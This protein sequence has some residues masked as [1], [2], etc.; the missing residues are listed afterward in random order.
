MPKKHRIL[1]SRMGVLFLAL[2]L[3]GACADDKVTG[4][5]VQT[6]AVKLELSQD[7]PRTIDDDFAALVDSIPGFGGWFVD[8]ANG[9]PIVV[10]RNLSNLSIAE[11]KLRSRVQKALANSR[12]ASDARLVAR[13]GD[14]DFRQLY[15]WKRI[16]ENI[17]PT[18]RAAVFVDANEALNRVQIGI[19]D[20]AATT[21]ITKK[22][23]QHGVPIEAIV[24]TI[25]HP[26]RQYIDLD[27][28]VRP[29]PAGVVAHHNSTPAGGCTLG[30]SASQATGPM[31]FVTNSHCTWAL[32]NVTTATKFG[33]PVQADS[34]GV[35]VEDPSPWQNSS[36]CQWWR[37]FYPT[38]VCRFSDAA[39]VDYRHVSSDSV[40]FG[41]IA[42]TT[43]RGLVGF[44]GTIVID[45][46]N[47]RFEIASKYY[48]VPS[49]VFVEA[50]GVTH[51]WRTLQ[52]TN[53][54]TTAVGE[55][56]FL[57]W[58]QIQATGNAGGGDS[59]APVFGYDYCDDGQLQRADGTKCV[60]LA[61]VIWG[62]IPENDIV[63][64]SPIGGIENDM[65]TMGVRPAD[66]P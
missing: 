9:Q 34:M 46:N 58:C 62:G 6:E 29:I 59:G 19:S 57:L 51:G 63:F 61:G 45:A 27:D 39:F 35:E 48:S 14:Y 52:T 15:A 64:I 42:R 16:A 5:L 55:N 1:T 65:G 17:L 38:A 30:F 49:G 28:R 60:K 54:C 33:Q 2:L 18:E 53:S 10:L 41:Y 21:S 50:V 13:Q 25:V 24:I 20:V 22:M 11:G 44:S 31:G 56:N 8:A 23:Q 47:P 43:Q 4:L 3:S 12:G 37:T 7:M 40:K 26:V 66:K 32:G 36:G